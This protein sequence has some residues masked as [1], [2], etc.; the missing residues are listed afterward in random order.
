MTLLLLCGFFLFLCV[1]RIA[2]EIVLVRF[3]DMEI[4]RERYIWT[5][6]DGKFCIIFVWENVSECDLHLSSVFD[7]LLKTTM[8]LVGFNCLERDCLCPEL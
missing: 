1:F 2:T 7:W 8:E 3:S 4:C 5:F 6:S